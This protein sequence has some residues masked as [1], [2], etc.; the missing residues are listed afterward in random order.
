MTLYLG[1]DIAKDTFT[2]A[3]FREEERLGQGEF[4]NTSTGFKQLHTYLKK[5]IKAETLHAC[6]EATGYYGDEL[7]RFLLDAGYAVSVVNP[8]RIKHYGE[9]QLSR[10]KTD[11]ADAALIA[12]F[13]RTQRPS[14]WVPPSPPVLELRAMVRHVLALIDLRQQE[15]NRSKS[16]IASPLV[17][18]TI[19][20]HIEFLDQQIQ[21]LK[22]RIEDHMDRF[23]ELKQQRDILTS[24]PGIGD[25]T[26]AQLLVE[27]PHWS[28]FETGKQMA[29]YAGLSPAIRESGKSVRK[30]PQLSKRGSSRIRKCLFF[31]AIS[32]KNHNP[33]L[34]HFAQR[35]EQAGKNNMLIIG[36]I[37]RKLLVLAFALL[38][39][40]RRF[41]AQFA[42]E[43]SNTP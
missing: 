13:C 1:I 37:M 34:A 21:D 27:L 15:V 31:P 40:G 4:A 23:P 29:A 35:L 2:I 18:E 7:A 3:L 20:Q 24:I 8:A 38:K 30:K 25:W 43:V 5:R 39:S 41:D 10:T 11:A 14:A 22:R 42:L 28:L 26:A 17:L 33:V 6:L 32:A 36:A 16:G 9:S 19:A 12:D